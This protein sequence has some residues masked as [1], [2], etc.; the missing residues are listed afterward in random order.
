M[1]MLPFFRKVALLTPHHEALR[2]IVESTGDRVWAVSMDQ[3]PDHCDF[4]V[5]YGYRKIIREPWLT[6]YAGRLVNLHTSLLPWN[7]GAHPNVWAWHD[8]TPHGVTI[9]HIDAGLDTGD[10][11]AQREVPMGDETLASSYAKLHT[12][13][14][15]L[16]AET[17]PLIRAGTAPRVPQSGPGSFHRVAD[18]PPLPMG[19]NTPAKAA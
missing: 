9:H 2:L 6:R 19:W 4:V 5:S 3:I 8:G 12:A 7:R 14:L 13:M 16:F 1:T 17:W 18:L 15:E 11:I 10:I